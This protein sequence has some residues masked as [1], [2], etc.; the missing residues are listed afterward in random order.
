LIRLVISNQRGGVAKTTTAVNV[1][2]YFADQGQKVLIIDT[3]PQGSVSSVLGLRSEHNLHSFVIKKLAF[4]ECLVQAHA[5]IDVMCSARD[6]VQTE[7]ILMGETA[8]ELTFQNLFPSVDRGYDVV[9]ID[10]APSISLLQTCAMLYARQLLIPV[11]MDGLSLQGAL[12]SIET[13]RMLSDLF[14]S[15]IKTAALLP[16]MVD[17]RYQMTEMVME[18][19]KGM[20]ERYNV[21]LLSPIRTD[22]TVT[23]AS[24]QKQFLAD[25]DPKCKALEDYTAACR[26]LGNL[27]KDQI[28]V[29]PIATTA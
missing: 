23:K 8:R 22:A 15:E 19:L 7:A 18:S 24:R 10:V 4:R 2:R 6:T 28:H 5:N 26:E 12:A 1:A 17:R 25:Y 16:V 13:A 29:H 11:S 21:P 3:D 9:L 20:S 27:L 14:R